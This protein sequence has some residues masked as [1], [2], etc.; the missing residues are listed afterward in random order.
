MKIRIPMLQRTVAACTTLLACAGFDAPGLAAQEAEELSM[1]QIVRI[2]GATVLRGGPASPPV[3]YPVTLEGNVVGLQGDTLLFETGLE[4]VY[5]IP[6]GAG[7]LL[8]RRATVTDTKRMI[9]V[10]G[11]VSGLAGATFSWALKDECHTNEA[12]LELGI[13]LT[14]CRENESGGRVALRG[15]AVGAAAGVAAGL[16]LGRFAK[17]QAWIPVRLD[18]LGFRGTPG[19]GAAEAG[20]VFRVPV[21]GRP[22]GILSGLANST[23]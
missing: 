1:G 19:L 6:L 14:S 21:G 3:L 18:G 4:P 12:A 10:A 13:N 22:G 11:G 15:F 8:E 20:I 9:L 2:T 7:E 17:R 23:R 5:W 16:V